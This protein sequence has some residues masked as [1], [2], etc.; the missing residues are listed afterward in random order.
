M[1]QV[2]LWAVVDDS[3]LRSVK[4]SARREHLILAQIKGE[5]YPCAGAPI[6]T[7]GE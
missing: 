2:I 3:P 5:L 7:S 6:R 1:T 4:E